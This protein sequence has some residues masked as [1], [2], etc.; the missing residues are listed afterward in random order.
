[1][2][3]QSVET[4]STMLNDQSI[5]SSELVNHYW[6]QIKSMN[7]TLNAF[8]DLNH[9]A[10][11]EA[12]RL[13]QERKTKGPRSLFHGIPVVIKDN[14]LTNDHMRTTVNSRVFK[15]YFAS[16]DAFIVKCLRDAGAI[17]LGKTTLSEFA[18]YMSK[19]TMPSGYGSLMGQTISA[20]DAA[21]DPLGS[22][23]GSA[24]AVS[25]GMAPIAIGTETNGSLMSPAKNNSLVSIKPTLGVVSRH[26]IFPISY[27]QD[28]AGPLSQTVRDSAHLLD[29]IK[30]YDA[31]D[32]AS[33]SQ[34]ANYASA[35]KEPVDTMRI[36]VLNLSI[37]KTTDTHQ[38]IKEEA[39]R[40]FEA[41]GVQCIEIDH[42]YDLPNNMHIL[43]S[44][45]K[46]DMNH[47][48]HTLS[49]AP[50]RSFDALTHANRTR[51]RH[52]LKH[53]QG[54]FYDALGRDMTL[55]DAT[56]MDA[57]LKTN[58]SIARFLNLF[59]T[60]NLD[61][62]ITPYYHPYAAVGGLPSVSVP[63]KTI[64]DNAPESLLFVGRPFS[65]PALIT[66]AYRYEQ[67]TQHRETPAL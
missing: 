24:V 56:Y 35:T 44:E 4:L 11:L 7:P 17:I 67:K 51:Y 57:R 46:R 1:V 22:S 42:T 50:V 23:T 61:A 18:Y 43:S 62:I 20:F 55:S 6:K 60:H 34:P 2:Q 38:T 10:F 45:M 21:L 40:V 59:D 27:N 15:N 58:D 8:I 65:E 12:R 32:S 25:A 47:F 16:E 37:A 39:M 28:T 19:T 64:K 5:T 52:N 9:E 30:G 14:I 53:G 3:N 36:G 66:L 33:T 49:N 54:L 26:G 13:D 63:A 29:V 31:S 48:L 41:E